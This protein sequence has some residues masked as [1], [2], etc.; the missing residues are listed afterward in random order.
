MASMTFRAVFIFVN[1]EPLVEI[2]E[3]G[4]NIEIPLRYPP[5]VLLTE[6]NHPEV[7][8]TNRSNG[9][10]RRWQILGYKQRHEMRKLFLSSQARTSTL[11]SL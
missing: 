10:E 11:R 8:I 7:F 5:T 3:S 2:Y 1:G 4:K 6:G 9:S